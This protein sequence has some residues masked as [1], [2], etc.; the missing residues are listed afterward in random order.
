[1]NNKQKSEFVKNLDKEQLKFFCELCINILKN[2]IKLSDEAKKTLS[3]QKIK[4]RALAGKSPLRKKKKLI[5]G[6]FIGGLLLSLATSLAPIVIE[7]LLNGKGKTE[8]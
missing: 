8:N 2:N 4:I 5:T 7:K 1:M 3:K 6:G